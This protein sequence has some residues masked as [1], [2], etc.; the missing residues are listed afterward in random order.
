MII[1]SLLTISDIFELKD[2]YL[3]QCVDLRL[4]LDKSQ[5]FQQKEE[6]WKVPTLLGNTLAQIFWKYQNLSVFL[7]NLDNVPILAI[8]KN[9]NSTM[10]CIPWAIF[11]DSTSA[12]IL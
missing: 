5:P 2:R 8:G 3:Q 12:S 11:F 10:L 1:V 9:S 6:I 4:L 7:I